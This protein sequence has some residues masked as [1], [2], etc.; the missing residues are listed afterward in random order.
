MT[1]TERARRG[2]LVR[3]ARVDDPLRPAAHLSRG[4]RAVAGISPTRSRPASGPAWS[5]SGSGSAARCPPHP[6]P[7]QRQARAHRGVSGRAGVGCAC[8]GEIRGQAAARPRLHRALPRPSARR[9]QLL[10]L[11]G[12]QPPRRRGPHRADLPAGLPALRARTARVERPAAAAVADPHRAQ[13]R[14]ELL[15]RPLAAAADPARG[16]GDRVRART[17]PRTSSRDGRSYSTCSRAWRS[18]RTTAARR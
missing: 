7:A 8:V 3:P 13:P 5:S 9:L 10:V 6:E 4:R 11:P 12:R 2:W 16:R 18:C 17:T 1:G 15:P 14:R